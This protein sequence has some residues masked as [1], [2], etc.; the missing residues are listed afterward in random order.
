[1]EKRNVTTEIK[2]RLRTD[3]I[4]DRLVTFA[5]VTDELLDKAAFEALLEVE[6][7]REAGIPQ[8]RFD[9]GGVEGGEFEHQEGEEVHAVPHVHGPDCDHD[10][11]APKADA[12]AEVPAEEAPAKPK[13][14]RKPKAAAETEAAP[15]AEAAAETTEA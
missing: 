6:R 2:G 8:A 9:A 13:R 1:M 11:E 4:F 12:A 10:H 7:R 15:E 3:K 14:A 5:T